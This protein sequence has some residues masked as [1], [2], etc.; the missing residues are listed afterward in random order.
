MNIGNLKFDNIAFLAPM[1]GIADRAF[2]ELCTDFG[3]AYTV[4]EMVSSKGLTMGDRKSGELLTIGS[5]RPCAAQIFG[6]D[7]EIMAKAAV[8]CLEYSPEVIDINMGCPA[9]KV[10]MNGGGASLLKNPPLAFE[11]IKAV[12]EAVG[13]PFLK[14]LLVAF[15]VELGAEVAHDAEE[16]F[17]DAEIG[18]RIERPHRIQKEFMLVKNPGQAIDHDVIVADIRQPEIV[19]PLIHAEKAVGA[20]VNLL[21]PQIKALRHTADAFVSLIYGHINALFGKLD[22]AGKPRRAS[23]YDSYFHIYSLKWQQAAHS[24]L[25]YGKQLRVFFPVRTGRFCLPEAEQHMPH[26]IADK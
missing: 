26:I 21:T 2:R 13:H 14:G 16:G 19:Y 22:S 1:A 5:E 8:K 10:A 15:L 18:E 23:P 20:K 11:V 3:A 12:A 4:T 17:P 7:P 25:F 9:P 6:D 24:F